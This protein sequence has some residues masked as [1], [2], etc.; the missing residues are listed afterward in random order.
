MKYDG[1][2]GEGGRW[3]VG[4]SGCSSG[5]NAFLGYLVDQAPSRIVALVCGGRAASPLRPA[6]PGIAYSALVWS[7]S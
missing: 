2:D 1:G 7:E 3:V 5:C 6:L 4:R